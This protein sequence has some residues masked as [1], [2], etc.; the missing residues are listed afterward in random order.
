MKKL[1]FVAMTILFG[2]AA[3][4]QNSVVDTLKAQKEA[5]KLTTELNKLQLSYEKEKAN[6]SKLNE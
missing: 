1:L 3:Y 6:Y 2:I 4:A 5:L